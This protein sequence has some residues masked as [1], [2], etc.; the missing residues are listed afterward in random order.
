[1]IASDQQF[2]KGFLTF[3]QPTSKCD[4]LRLAYVQALSIKLTQTHNQYAVIITP[5]LDV[6]AKYRE[7]FDYVIPVVWG[8]AAKDQEWKLDNE[9]KA[10][11]QTPFDQTVK[12]DCDMLFMEDIKTWWDVYDLYD[13][14]PTLTTSTY[15][16]TDANDDYYR[17]FFRDNDL[18]NFYSGLFYFR[19]SK[20]AYELFK[21]CEWVY[22]NWESRTSLFAGPHRPPKIS[23]DVAF[24]VAAKIMG[25]NYACDIGRFTHMKKHIQDIDVR[26]LDEDWQKNFAFYFDENMKLYVENFRQTN[27]FHYHQKDFITEDIII[28]YERALGI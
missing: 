4:Y 5:G 1:M 20:E 7:V 12:L 3:A 21:A 6:P 18:P 25:M 10:F 22:K 2:S 8:D 26:Q 23:T 19:N 15:R 17:Q 11:Y 16:G 9:W 24:A 14:V 27:P 13:V 28:R